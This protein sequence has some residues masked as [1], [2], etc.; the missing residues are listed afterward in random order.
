MEEKTYEIVLGDV[1]EG[2]SGVSAGAGAGE[3]WY[4]CGFGFGCG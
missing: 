2:V 4:G 3:C 1:Q